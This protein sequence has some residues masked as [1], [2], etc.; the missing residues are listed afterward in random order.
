MKFWLCLIA[1]SFS[2]SVE[3]SSR[4]VAEEVSDFALLDSRGK[5]YRLRRTSA[6]AVVLFFTANGCPVAE[7]SFEK[8]KALQKTFDAEG[9]QIW[10]VDSNTADDRRSLRRQM[11]R[12]K[13]TTLPLLQ[14]ETQGVA[15]M[16][17]VKRT[18]TCVAIETKNWSVFYRGALD[19]QLFE[20]GSKPAPT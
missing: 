3:A 15:A 14:D 13:L 16:L 4:S 9:V 2:F 12:F 8:L 5:E 10:L 17:E 7:K 11:E 19:D 20:G 1:L 18:A 6:R